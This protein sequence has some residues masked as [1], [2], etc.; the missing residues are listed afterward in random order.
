MGSLLAAHIVRTA[1][2]VESL[3]RLPPSVGWAAYHEPATGAVLIDVFH[4]DAAPRHPFRRSPRLPE[5]AEALPGTLAPLN[6]LYEA[7]LRQRQASPFRRRYIN[8][9]LL[10][11]RTIDMPVFSFA[12]DDDGLDLACLSV[13]GQLHRLRFETDR[14]EI[15]WTEGHGVIQPLEF[16]D[17]VVVPEAAL[18]LLESLSDFKVM[19]SQQ[20]SSALHQIA[21]DECKVFL[22]TD[23][24]ILGL[25]S[26]DG[27]DN[28]AGAFMRGKQR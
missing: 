23:A 18:R 9:N 12:S 15:L 3:D 5:L 22:R 2:A 20:G 4:A 26:G 16:D 7:L 25:G 10:L 21:L 8:L 6:Q 27:Y 14:L 13:A 11:S 28:I 17:D 24:S 19:A 1:P